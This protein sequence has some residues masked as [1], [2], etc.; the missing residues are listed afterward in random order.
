M[1]VGPTY[2]AKPSHSGNILDMKTRIGL[3]LLALATPLSLGQ[4]IRP[5]PKTWVPSQARSG[6]LFTQDL[7]V[8]SPDDLVDELLGAGVT[9]NNIAFTGA[10]VAG[11]LFTGGTGIVG[12]ERGIVLSTGNVGTI[13]GPDNTVDDASTDNNLPGDSDLDALG[14]GSTQDAA[15]LTFEFECTTSNTISFQFVFM[16][17]EYNEFVQT[18]FNDGFALLLNG[19]N[20]ALV[21]SAGIPV[22]IDN[23]NC[24]GP[25]SPP[26]GT[27][28][29]LFINNDCS[30]VVG[31]PCA[32]VATEMDGLTAVFSASGPVVPGPNTLK[33]VIGDV[34]DGLYD[35]NVI[36][37][38]QSLSCAAPAPAFDPPTPCDQT[39][40]VEVGSP[41]TF[42]AVAIATS[43]VAGQT[44]SIDATGSATALSDGTFTPA[45][46][47]T[48]ATTTSTDYSWTPT[49]ADIGLHTITLIATDQLGQTTEC[50]IDILVA[51]IGTIGSLLC[52]PN[53]ANST[54]RPARLWAIGSDAV[55]NNDLTLRLADAP[56]AVFALA[57]NS[58]EVNVVANPGGSMGS[59]CIE[60]LA[61]GRHNQIALTSSPAGT[62]AFSIDLTNMP[63]EPGGSIAVLAG[64][65]WYWQVWYRDTVAGT[66]TAN[67]SNA[68]CVTFQ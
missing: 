7:N 68:I 10:S 46:P 59:L 63:Y 47:T 43:G 51:P 19:Q 16:S 2:R 32:Q 30:D 56:P 60:S 27:N 45:L 13:E 66:Q 17:E 58:Q 54:G 12:F 49:G 28:C 42:T 26:G 39:L 21:P 33:F 37:R 34:G 50:D 8:V 14:G 15:A 4:Q 65:T 35:S 1:E 29:G 38:G 40:N 55:G 3:V 23:V 62:G 53:E 67:W 44:V 5:T 57:F 36:I 31:S 61:M 6:A 48:P 64:E 11:G 9:V 18:G 22:S 41:V 25:F 24:G 20:I 52:D